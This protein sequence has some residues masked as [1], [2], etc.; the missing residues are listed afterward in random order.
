MGGHA[1]Q[2]LSLVAWSFAQWGHSDERLHKAIQRTLLPHGP[3]AQLPVDLQPLEQQQQQQQGGELAGRAAHAPNA[4]PGEPNL[5]P[6][7]VSNF[8]FAL[9]KQG[10]HDPE[11]VHALRLA[12]EPQI[13]RQANPPFSLHSSP[14]SSPSLAS[15]PSLPALPALL[16]WLPML[17]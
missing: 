6:L 11:L 7:T 1:S 8:A 10:V 13:H 12:A 14:S 4:V 17:S 5:A 16:L 15:P 9:A 2:A 3:A